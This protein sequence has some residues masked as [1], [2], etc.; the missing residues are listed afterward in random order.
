MTKVQFGNESGPAVCPALGAAESE[1]WAHLDATTKP[2]VDSLPP[3]VPRR[4]REEETQ[5][6]VGVSRC[7]RERLA[8]EVFLEL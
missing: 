2:A 7:A 3:L 8:L 5:A 4:E 6:M 1:R